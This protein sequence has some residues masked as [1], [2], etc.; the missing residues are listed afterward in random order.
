MGRTFSRKER[1]ALFL[2][3]DGKC[4][5]CGAPLAEGWHADHIQPYSK[6]GATD[7]VNGQ[8][9]CPKCNLSKGNRTARPRLKW[10]DRF[11]AS[12]RS[13]RTPNFLLVATPAAGK[14]FAACAAISEMMKNGDVNH[15]LVVAPSSSVRQSWA[16]TFAEFD[17]QIDARFQNNGTWKSESYPGLAVTYQSIASDVLIYRRFTSRGKWVVVF[18]E[19]HHLGSHEGS[20]WGEAAVAIAE[21]AEKRILLSGTPFRTDG[22][23]IPFV[24]YEGDVAVPDLEYSYEEAVK[25][26][27]VRRVFFKH[28][29]AKVDW[30]VF[31]TGETVEAS[32]EDALGDVDSNRRLTT[33]LREL[34]MD[35][36][37][38]TMIFEANA[39]LVEIRRDNPR[40][41]GMVLCIDQKHAHACAGMMGQWLGITPIVAVSDEPDSQ[42]RI[43]Q[44]KDGGQPWLVSVQMVSEGTDIPRLQV[45]VYATTTTTEMFFRQGVGR[46]IRAEFGGDA[47]IF[48]VDDPRLKRM[49][50]VYTK[51]VNASIVEEINRILDESESEE[52]EGRDPAWLPGSSEG[53]ISGVIHDGDDVDQRWLERAKKAKQEYGLVDDPEK[54]AFM[55]R[56]EYERGGEEEPD[57]PL[58]PEIIVERDREQRL[59]KQQ[60]KVVG[61]IH[62]RH[63]V[64]YKLINNTLNKAVGISAVDGEAATIHKLEA[65]LLAARDW[66][67]TGEAP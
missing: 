1:D 57:S 51:T 12:I 67:S 20:S 52:R 59:R 65:R 4:E 44:F 29:W 36:V 64:E 23:A 66:F 37:M 17:I 5:K 11:L 40:A 14:T 28:F 43:Q 63:E 38:H 13:H 21:N 32:F 61:A 31:A 10:Q 50:E 33:A 45:G 2:A 26:G 27:I 9:L 7:V 56:T 58:R 53:G 19:V 55:L 47:K 48:L 42:E 62:N 25:D 34:D 24:H 3:A 60:A 30:T 15:V 18:D 46:Y 49:A 6:D 35:S 41:G 54:I 16:E 22:K 39:D 8:A